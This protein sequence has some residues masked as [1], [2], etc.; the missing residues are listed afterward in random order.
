M[1]RASHAVR[2]SSARP[3]TT[4]STMKRPWLHVLWLVAVLTLS[5]HAQMPT[6]AEPLDFWSVATL[7]P[8]GSPSPFVFHTAPHPEGM[9][10]LITA[11]SGGGPYTDITYRFETIGEPPGKSRTARAVITGGTSCLFLIRDPKLKELHWFPDTK[12]TILSYHSKTDKSYPPPPPLPEANNPEP[13][14]PKNAPDKP[15]HP[16]KKPNP[17]HK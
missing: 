1:I 5:A 13:S 8:D 17:Q 12:V 4:T 6:P 9:L 2:R 10:V 16:D 15:I 11:R 14:K 3:K 7:M